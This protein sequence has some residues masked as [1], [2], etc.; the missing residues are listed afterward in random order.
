MTS[1]GD[2]EVN[3]GRSEILLLL[4]LAGGNELILGRML[5]SLRGQLD[6]SLVLV[7]YL[8]WHTGPG[9]GALWGSCFGLLSDLLLGAHLLGL[10]GLSKTLVGFL[11]GALRWKVLVDGFL[12]CLLLLAAGS[13]LD[14]V[15]ISAI[16]G[17]LGQP[18]MEVSGWE[19][20]TRCLVTSC[21]GGII[22]RQYDR[23]KFP[24][25]DL[26][27]VGLASEDESA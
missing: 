1:Q 25:K 13:L 19:L 7:L 4:L 23:L 6:L 12:P 20:G 3:F 26:S 10:N 8:S 14:S 9:K 15:F 5:P 27:R 21:A 16:L 22:F 18:P 11:A 24:P 2:L 17:L